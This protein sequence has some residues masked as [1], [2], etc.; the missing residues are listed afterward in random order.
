MNIL[1]NPKEEKLPGDLGALLNVLFTMADADLVDVT[2]T[3]RAH[4]TSLK[5]EINT[6]GNG[7]TDQ[8]T[9]IHLKDMS[10]RLDEILNHNKK[11]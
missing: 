10:R 3:L 8:M 7:A 1:L 2:S 4:L 9:K 6:T 5:A 11:D